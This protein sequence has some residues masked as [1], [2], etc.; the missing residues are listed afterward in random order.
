MQSAEDDDALQ[1]ELEREAEE[2]AF[3][4]KLFDAMDEN[5]DGI[6]ASY[7]EYAIPSRWRGHGGADPAQMEEE[8]YAEYIRQGM[9][10]C[11]F[12]PQYSRRRSL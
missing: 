5:A 9:W 4:E 11:V 6:H 10:K 3:R 1:A 8:E 12:R 7:N 2:R